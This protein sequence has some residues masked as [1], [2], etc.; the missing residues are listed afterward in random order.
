MADTHAP[1][2]AGQTQRAPVSAHRETLRAA[3]KQSSSVPT[4]AGVATAIDPSTAARMQIL[5][6]STYPMALR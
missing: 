5:Y 1:T 3:T 2:K 6:S 4:A